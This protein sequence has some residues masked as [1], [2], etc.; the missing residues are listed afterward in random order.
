MRLILAVLALAACAAE[1]PQPTPPPAAAP[2]DLVLHIERPEAEAME[3]LEKL[4]ANCW[5]DSIV[6]GANLLVDR[7]AKRLVIVADQS[8]LLDVRFGVRTP[9]RSQLRLDGPA[10]RDPDKARGL[11]R[12]LD[13]ADR[14]GDTV[15]TS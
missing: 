3:L 9:L 12:T 15:C 11:A 14:T 7:G 10:A 2:A 13:T 5:L 1:P 6:G 8:E 4:A